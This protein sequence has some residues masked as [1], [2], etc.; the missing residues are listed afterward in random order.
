MF[1]PATVDVGVTVTVTVTSPGHVDADEL[2]I[3][4]LELMDWT[5]IEDDEEVLGECIVAEEVLLD[6]VED[7]AAAAEREDVG[8]KDVEDSKDEPEDT[9]LI[10]DGFWEV[11]GDA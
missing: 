4:M 10:V 3:D 7:V 2:I 8:E 9:A 1:Y 11:E 6:V 5:A